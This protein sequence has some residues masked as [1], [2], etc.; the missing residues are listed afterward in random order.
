[1]LPKEFI[2]SYEDLRAAFR[3]NYLRQTK[4]IK[5]P[6]EIHHIKQRDGESTED[7]MER[8]KA[9][10]DYVFSARGSRRIQS[11]SGNKPNFRKGF[12]NKQRS[13]RNP[14]RFSL[15]TK[16]PKEIFALEKGRFKAPPPMVTPA[17]KRDPNKYFE[18]Y[19][20][21]GHSTDECMQLRKHI[22]EMIKSGKLSQFIKELKHN[23]KPKAP[24]KGETAGKDKPLTIL[25]VQS[26]EKVAKQRITQ[27]FSP[28]TIISFP[29][30]GD[31]DET[32]GPMIIEAE[33]GG[34]FALARNK[35]TDGPGY[36]TPH[37]IQWRNHLAARSD[38]LASKNR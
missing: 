28:G 6:V 14:D 10:G 7:F 38:I 1:K 2:N 4:H 37:R 31:K 12:K 3:E 13:D 27:S 15:L 16:T 25:M 32:E 26:W 33:I 24:K 30:L 21:T 29:P 9:E 19:A 11:W 22:D 5:D 23:D 34:H 8:Y 20:D 35:K 18:F 17:E 36:H